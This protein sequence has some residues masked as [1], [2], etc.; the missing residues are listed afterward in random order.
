MAAWSTRGAQRRAPSGPVLARSRNRGRVR[1]SSSAAVAGGIV[2]IVVLGVLLAGVV[3]MNVAV[4]RLNMGLDRLGRERASLIAAER[5]AGGTA[6]E[7][8]G[9]AEDPGARAGEARLRPGAVDP[10]HLRGARAAREVS[11]RLVNRRI[12]L[13]LAFL[14]LAFAATFAR[15]VWLQGVQAASL[16]RMAASQHRETVVIPAGRGTIYDRT[17]VQL[18][19]G[20]Q[21]DD[22]L[23][24][25]EAD[26]RS[27][28]GRARRAAHALGDRASDA[29]PRAGRPFA[30][31]RLPRAQ[32][33]PGEGCGARE[34]RDQRPRVLPRGEAHVPAGHR[35][36]AGARLRR[37]GQPRPRPGSSSSSTRRSPGRPAR[38]RS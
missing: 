15:A 12:R 35:R 36:V 7:R 20:E 32:G 17:G 11:R 27:A 29:L 16:S 13:L 5:R 34:A 9:G 4:L 1:P 2:W 38:R 19:I 6:L 22:R 18:A 23:R 31:L 3:A 28:R 25:P 8:R 21:D 14:V 26:H 37:G 33:R 24:R 30:R 10:D